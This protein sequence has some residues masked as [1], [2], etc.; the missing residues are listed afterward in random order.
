[1]LPP[2]QQRKSPRNNMLWYAT[3]FLFIKYKYLVDKQLI[4]LQSDTQRAQETLRVAYRPFFYNF[5]FS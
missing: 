3:L 1:M 4:L 2:H 5:S